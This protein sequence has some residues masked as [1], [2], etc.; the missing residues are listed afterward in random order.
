MRD[1]P[2][3]RKYLWGDFGHILKTIRTPIDQ[4]ISGDLREYLWPLE[5][6]G[7]LLNAY[8]QALIKSPLDGFV[9]L[10]AVHHIACNVW[11]DLRG[12][13]N[14]ATDKPS[15]LLS[16]VVEQGDGSVV[17]EILRYR[18]DHGQHLLPPACF[19]QDGDWKET[20]INF[21]GNLLGGAMQTRLS[22]LLSGVTA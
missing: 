20:R 2:D 5:T 9:R 19:E 16:A 8:L 22:P 14:H 21:V 11:P 7:L 10:I 12:N 18:N 17:K 3:Y 4:V 1:A 6:D 13:T 15:K